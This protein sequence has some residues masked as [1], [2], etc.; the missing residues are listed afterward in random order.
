VRK[1]FDSYS[2]P[3]LLLLDQLKAINVNP[4][5]Q[6]WISN[7]LSDRLQFVTVEG[8]ASDRL[9]VVSGVPQGSVLGPLLFVMYINNVATVISQDSK[10]NMFADDI[11]YYR[12]VKSPSDYIILF[13]KMWTA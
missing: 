3:H 5:L 4:Y 12:I 2:V 13:K 7:Y 9:P 8:E 6:K 1:A 10:I 11:A